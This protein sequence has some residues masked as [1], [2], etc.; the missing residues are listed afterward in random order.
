MKSITTA[1]IKAFSCFLFIFAI[2]ISGGTQSELKAQDAHFSQNYATPLFINPAMTGL[3]NGDI[4]V[5]GVYRNQWMSI[6]PGTSFRTMYASADMAFQ[7]IGQNDRIGAGA[8]IYNDVAGDLNFHTTYIDLS[9]AYNVAISPTTFISIGLAGGVAQR[10]FDLSNAQFGDTYDPNNPSSPDATSEAIAMT[11]HWRTNL[12]GGAVFYTAPERRRNFY[13][14]A[15]LY[16]L[17]SAK[18]TF[19]ENDEDDL[20]FTKISGQVGGSF[21]LGDKLDLVPSAYYIGQ[22]PYMKTDVGTFLRYIFSADRRTGL[23]KAINFGAW[24]RASSGM[25]SYINMSA[26]IL[27]SKIDYEQFSVGVSYDMPLGAFAS[28]SNGS[29]SVEVSLIYTNQVREQKQ[30]LYC[31]RF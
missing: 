13:V 23:D 16:H 21:P 19:N 22:G 30:E 8:L 11:G 14:G 4:R 26:I 20:L 15:G 9:A 31:P 1:Y 17:N 10:G 18:I 29:G 2:T 24:A 27:A 25:D 6:M 7:G 12:G 3:M 5:S 28:A